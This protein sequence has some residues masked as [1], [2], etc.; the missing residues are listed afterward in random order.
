[1]SFWKFWYE[2]IV[3]VI[4]HDPDRVYRAQWQRYGR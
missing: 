4:R 1:M 2:E 3:G